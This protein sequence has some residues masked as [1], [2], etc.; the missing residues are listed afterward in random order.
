MRGAASVATCVLVGLLGCTTPIP[1]PL[2]T[3][4]V[5]PAPVVSLAVGVTGNTSDAPLFIAQ[6]KGYFREQGFEA[7]FTTFQSAA[8]AIAPLASGQIAL[9]AGTI[10]AGLFN[11]VARGLDLKIV[12]DK[13]Q[14]SGTPENGFTSALA[15]TVPKADAEAGRYRTFADLKGKTVAMTGTGSGPEVMLD[16]GLQTAG[17]STTDVTLKTLAFPDMLTALSNHSIDLAVEI[18]PF[19]TQGRSRGILDI[20]KNS[21]DIY[22]GQQGGV[23]MYG[24]AVASLGSETGDRV[25][26]A[27]LKALRD[28][29]DAFGLKHNN[30]PE[31]IAI[32]TRYTSVKDPSLYAQM[33]WDYMNPDGYVNRD[34]IGEDLDWYAAHGYV[35]QAPALSQVVDNSFV[36]HALQ[37]LGTYQP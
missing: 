18:E 20:W 24:P 28:Y 27:Y 31:I 35:T 5:T 15:L 13:G 4:A 1:A 7:T 34:A 2:P 22:T 12:A 19:V 21:E 8:D 9:S 6:D 30:Q 36:D 29:Y 14:H 37:R 11:A 32:L 25:M 16:K 3:A 23:L 33:G 17:L 26:V 10:G